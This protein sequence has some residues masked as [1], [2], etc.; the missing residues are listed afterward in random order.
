M[1]FDNIMHISLHKV[2]RERDRDFLFI[3]FVLFLNGPDN[4][5]LPG[6]DNGKEI[7]AF[8]GIEIQIERDR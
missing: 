8:R 1:A 6:R 5:M 7:K 2:E 4:I 3:F